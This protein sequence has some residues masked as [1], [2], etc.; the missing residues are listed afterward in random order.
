MNKKI[1]GLLVAVLTVSA[2]GINAHTEHTYLARR[3]ISVNLPMELTTFYERTQAK[4]GDRFG[5][6]L[7]V[8]GFYGETNSNHGEYFGIND[9]GE[10]VL[11]SSAVASAKSTVNNEFDL[12][13]VIHLYNRGAG[14]DQDAQATIKYDPEQEFYGVRFDYYQNMDKI[15]K[16]LY[17]KVYTTIA[18]ADN[19]MHL[20][21]KDVTDPLIAN[22]QTNLVNYFKGDYSDTTVDNNN[23]QRALTH[24][25]IDG[26]HSETGV[27]DVEVILGYKFLYKDKYHMGINLGIT[28]PTG[29]D[30]DGK[31]MWEP[32]YGNHSHFGFGAGLDGHARLWGDSDQNIKLN[33]ALNYRYLFEGSETRPLKLKDYPSPYVLLGKNGEQPLV[34]AVNVLTPLGVDVTPGSQVDG[35]LALAY[36]NGG[37]CADLGYNLY[38][39]EREDVDIKNDLTANTYG[40]A[41][42]SFQTNNN[43]SVGGATDFD[44]N[45]VKWLAKS[46][47]DAAAAETPSQFTNSIYGGLG[48]AFKKWDYPLMM[49]VGGK[50][51]WASKNSEFDNW[52]LWIKLA[53]SF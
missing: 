37:F 31:Y 42:R 13:Y 19:D 11:R 34:P 36:N 28:I 20:E 24:G 27:A 29:N 2:T 52:Q 41:A 30:P 17:L 3:S 39:R 1:K 45:A 33:F 12:G 23:Q 5:G 9:K 14:A 25:M 15:L 16:G 26:S 21:V 44:G 49:G 43:F 51:E 35:V 10:Y 53:L 48:Y 46:D 22:L 18:C 38:F 7:Q 6:N 32:I 50:Y 47:V 8:T 40:V 4:L